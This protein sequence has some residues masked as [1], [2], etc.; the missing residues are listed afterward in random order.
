MICKPVFQGAS[1]YKYQFST[2]NQ[3]NKEQT[4]DSSKF[5][6]MIICGIIKKQSWEINYNFYSEFYFLNIFTVVFIHTVPFML[7]GSEYSS[8]Q[9][10]WQNLA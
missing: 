4:R 3:V 8:K 10:I 5:F 2:E 6:H 7:M 1:I 9:I